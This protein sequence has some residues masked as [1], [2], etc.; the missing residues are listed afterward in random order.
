MTR[1]LNSTFAFVTYRA[2]VMNELI[3]HIRI[4]NSINDSIPDL[5]LNFLDFTAAKRWFLPLS[6]T[7]SHAHIFCLPLLF[8]S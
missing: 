6:F 4:K 8:L 7:D 2:E 1:L 3:D 5:K